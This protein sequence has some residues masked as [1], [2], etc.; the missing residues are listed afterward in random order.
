MEIIEYRGFKDIF[1][2]LGK[3][4]NQ[5]YIIYGHT[6]KLNIKCETEYED[7]YLH[8]YLDLKFMT[9]K[10]AEINIPFLC[11]DNNSLFTCMTIQNKKS[12]NEIVNVMETLL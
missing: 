3:E 8:K 7:I 4:K 11:K 6:G 5:Y 12:Y 1:I 2:A 9:R 10:T